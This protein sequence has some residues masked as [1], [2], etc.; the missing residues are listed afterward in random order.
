MRKKLVKKQT[1]TNESKTNNLSWYWDQAL[2]YY[3]DNDHK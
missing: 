2:Q 3:F 1:K